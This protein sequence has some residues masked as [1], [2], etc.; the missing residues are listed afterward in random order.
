MGLGIRAIAR[1]PGWRLVIYGDG[2]DEERLRRLTEQ[3]GVDDRVTFMGWRPREEVMAAMIEADVFLLPCLHEE[4]GWAVAEAVMCG[5]PAVSLD[6]GGPPV[7]GVHTV[8]A[9]WPAETVARLAEAVELARGEPAPSITDLSLAARRAR[10][11]T[12]LREHGALPTETTQPRRTS[13]RPASRPA[14]AASAG[15][16]RG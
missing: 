16:R 4:A 2:P 7:L 1:L 3:L 8:R 13:R 9:G 11:A 5:L 14:E 6:R 15:G 12:L 10:L